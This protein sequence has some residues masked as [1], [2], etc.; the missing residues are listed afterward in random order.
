MADDYE[1]GYGKPPVKT[2][3]KKGQS[4]NPK[5]R[6][7]KVKNVSTLLAI[8][9][10]KIIVVRDGS[11]ERRLTK[12]EALVTSLVNDAIKGKNQARAL[13]LKILE[14]EAPAEP[15][16]ADEQDEHVLADWLSRRE[17]GQGGREREAGEAKQTGEGDGDADEL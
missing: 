10:E 12:R 16:V 15:F 11:G 13:L 2:R 7:A 8:E 3:F 4:G 1:V 17:N 6:R 14:V 5:G 9:L